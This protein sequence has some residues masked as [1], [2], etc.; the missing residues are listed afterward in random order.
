MNFWIARRGWTKRLSHTQ[1]KAPAKIAGSYAVHAPECRC[2]T[3]IG[4]CGIAL[5]VIA[6]DV[7]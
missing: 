1:T 2:P 7:A 6:P 4:D 5:G 3:R